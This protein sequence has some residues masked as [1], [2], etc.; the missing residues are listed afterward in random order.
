VGFYRT[1][2]NGEREFLIPTEAFRRE[3]CKGMD[4]KTAV[5]V[6]KKSGLLI[7]AKDGKPSRV[8]RLPSLGTP[9]VYVIRYIGGAD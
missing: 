3:V 6:L 4:D 5:V 7:P 8:V 1:G 2:E 9:R